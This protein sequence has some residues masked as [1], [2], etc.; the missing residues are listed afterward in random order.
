[1]PYTIPERLKY[2]AQVP[3]LP[4][5]DTLPPGSIAVVSI[6]PHNHLETF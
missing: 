4:S 1:M 5:L 6:S 2:F 3:P